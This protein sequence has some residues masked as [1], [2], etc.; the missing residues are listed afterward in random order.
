MPILIRPI[1]VAD[2][3]DWH[4]LAQGY[5][6]FYETPTTEC[7]YSQAWE[8]LTAR[9]M[10]HGLAAWSGDRMVG[11]AHYL[12]HASTWTDKVCYLQDLFTLPESR[13]QGVA[14]A[15]IAATASAARAG[16]ASRYYWLTQAHNETARHLYDKVAKFHGF[17]RY[18]H[19][20]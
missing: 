13:G 3:A 8:R 14:R 18:D 17:I 9:G 16:G 11:I 12:F 1:S 2:F 4:P 6:A 7:E 19:P 10:S 15:L 5:K 20:L